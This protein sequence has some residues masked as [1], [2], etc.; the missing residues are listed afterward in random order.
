MCLGQE[1]DINDIL[2]DNDMFDQVQCFDS[3]FH[4]K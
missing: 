4:R 1:Y 3:Y 2:E